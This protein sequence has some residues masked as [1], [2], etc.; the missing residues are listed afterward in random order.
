[1]RMG[2]RCSVVSP[3]HGFHPYGPPS[4]PSQS[5]P[6]ALAPLAPVES[7]EALSSSLLP[8]TSCAAAHHHLYTGWEHQSPPHNNVG[9]SGP[10]TL[11]ADRIIA[12]P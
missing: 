7:S 10:F 8:E 3:G 4:E 11:V 12:L 1:M 9:T 6:T 5:E 2:L